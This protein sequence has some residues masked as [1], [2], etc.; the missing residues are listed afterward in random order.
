MKKD[1]EGGCGVVGFCS[2]EKIAGKHLIPPCIQMHNRGNGK[3]GGVVAMGLKA[4]QLNVT[5]E[6]LKTNYLI[7]IAFL[8]PEIREEVE[9]QFIFNNYDVFT[10][11]K[12]KTKN[13]S[14]SKLEI[15]RSS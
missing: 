1:V 7:Q 14:S 10:Q 9:S 2:T 11:Y 3:G 13:N 15:M 5:E 12:I 6:I 4:S 8:K